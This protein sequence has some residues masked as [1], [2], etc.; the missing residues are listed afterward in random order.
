MIWPLFSDKHEDQPFTWTIDWAEV[1][2][3][4]HRPPDPPPL[5]PDLLRD[6]DAAKE[7]AAEWMRRQERRMTQ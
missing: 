2:P 6:V 3:R 7:N 1:G 4:Y 5:S